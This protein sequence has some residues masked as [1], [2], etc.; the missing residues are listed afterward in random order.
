MEEILPSITEQDILCAETP[1]GPSAMVVFG[2]S[3]DLTRRKL[4]VSLAELFARDLIPKEFYLLGCGRTQY[5]DEQFRKMADESLAAA[6]EDIPEEVKKRFIERLYYLSGDYSD[7]STYGNMGIRL[8][9]L[10]ERHGVG[11]SIVFYLA[12]PPVLYT[13]IVKNLGDAGLACPENKPRKDVRLVVEKPFG[14][15]LN[16]AVE[17][18]EHIQQ[19]FEETQIYRIDHY[20]GKET[21]QNI[22]M[23]RFANTIFEP[24]WN[25]NHIDHVQITIAESVGVGRRGGYYD[26]SGALRD[27][28]QNHVTQMLSLVAMEPPAS[29][30]A[31]SVRDEKIKLLRSIR[32]LE[33]SNISKTVVRGRYTR[34]ILNGESVPGYMEEDG[35]DPESRTETYIAAKMFIDNWRW[36]D[37]PFYLRTGKRLARKNTEIAI[38]FNKPPHSMFVSM[39]LGD[40]PANVLVLRIQPEE[41]ISL[42]FQAKKP[43]SKACMATLNMSFEYES[44]FGVG[45]P[46][47]YQRL[48]LDCLLG[49]QTLFNRFDAV[50]K[51][52]EMLMPVLEYWTENPQTPQEYP[53]GSP[54]FERADQLIEAD[55]RKWRPL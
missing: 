51:S 38:T 31:D 9:E 44:I 22:L 54:S 32:P 11:G 24:V 26:K 50:Y 25:R 55:G 45:M 33:Q 42:S 6:D 36:R 7:S 15:D 1:A 2:A 43:G 23:F 8:R 17:L 21:V 48:L 46:E 5:S 12:V 3:G 35:V 13:T 39:G 16:S 53:A 19:C 14:R 27:M 29:F 49:D 47:S 30:E 4:L 28:F 34:G 41:G 18:N 52:W 10:N 40:L 37:V 20:L